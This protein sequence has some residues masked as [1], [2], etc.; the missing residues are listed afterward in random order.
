MYFHYCLITSGTIFVTSLVMF[1]IMK[2]NNQ[3]NKKNIL[4][5]VVC[6]AL[7][8]ICAVTAPLLAKRLVEGLSFSTTGSLVVSLIVI[9]CIASAIFLL[10]QPLIKKY[11]LEG[12]D[13]SGENKESLIEQM[14]E[15]SAQSA[16]IHENVEVLISENPDTG[17]PATINETAIIEEIE[18]S[19]VT[20]D[21]PEAQPKEPEKRELSGIFSENNNDQSDIVL[22]LDRAFELKN[23][24]NF[25]GAISYY[26][27]ALI[28]NPED[29]LRFLIILDLCALYKKTNQ[30]ELIN[31]I[32]EST[33]CDLLNL[34]IKE[35]ILRN[36]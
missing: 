7:S 17:D 25:Y 28:M 32:L 9:F 19:N 15:S 8:I 22:L 29:D 33:R 36:L 4:N 23:Q 12:M 10:L 24:R 6:T 3:V 5:L 20:K 14:I 21:M 11:S 26:E 1:Y 13:Q 34:E 31:K 30:P 18:T 35:D 27:T 16:A 2:K